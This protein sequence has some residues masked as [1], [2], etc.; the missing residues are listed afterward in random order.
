MG[1][2]HYQYKVLSFSHS[3]AQ[4]FFTKRPVVGAAYLLG[5]SISGEKLYLK[6]TQFIMVLMDSITAKATC[7][8]IDSTHLFLLSTSIPESTLCTEATSPKSVLCPSQDVTTAAL[9]PTAFQTSGGS[10]RWDVIASSKGSSFP[11]TMGLTI[12]VTREHPCLFSLQ[13]ASWHS[14]DATVT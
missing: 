9:V 13:V 11:L 7:C 6:Y 2:D 10:L 14:W 4:K 5:L 8:R 3:T 1:G 12:C